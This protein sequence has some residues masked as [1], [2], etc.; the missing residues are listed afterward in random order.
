MIKL[1][2]KSGTHL[3][4]KGPTLIGP[5]CCPCFVCASN[6]ECDNN[7]LDAYAVLI[8]CNATVLLTRHSSCPTSNC[9]LWVNVGQTV[10][11]FQQ[12]RDGVCYWVISIPSDGFLIMQ[13]PAS[14][15]STGPPGDY[16]KVEG[17]GGDCSATVS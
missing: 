15:P 2:G 14:G 17:S 5:S 4:V 16:V 7:F 1:K 13:G 11:L 3:L 12:V 6:E 8:T 10:S 9:C